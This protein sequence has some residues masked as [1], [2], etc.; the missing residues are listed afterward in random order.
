[1]YSPKIKVGRLPY[2]ALWG[3]SPLLE[4]MSLIN[5]QANFIKWTDAY[6]LTVT[7]ITVIGEDKI[8]TSVLENLELAIII[9]CRTC[10][11]PLYTSWLMGCHTGPWPAW[12]EHQEE[13]PDH[14]FLFLIGDPIFLHMQAIHLI[15]YLQAILDCHLSS[16]ANKSSN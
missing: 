16:L 3:A 4:N 15:M 1:V 10:Q 14:I 8:Q 6:L 2:L 7:V 11:R 9:S 5:F 13:T 12:E